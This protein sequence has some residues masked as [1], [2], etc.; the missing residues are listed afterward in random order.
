M[1]YQKH[2]MHGRHIAING[3]EAESNRKNGWVDVKEA[4]FYN[5]E[6]T[7]LVKSSEE[8]DEEKDS[9][10]SAELLYK[11]KFGKKPHHR[12]GTETIM[13]ALDDN[14]E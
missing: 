8:T 2:H 6:Q 9:R 10:D 4:E 13:K 5:R 11:I 3:L 7:E 12:M 14:G 1:I